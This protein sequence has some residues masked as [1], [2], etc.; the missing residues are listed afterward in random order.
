MSFA[1]DIKAFALKCG[2]NADFVVRSVVLDIGKSL[3]MKTPV[4]NPDLWQNPEKKPKG[5]AG[6]HAR[7][8]WQHSVN[9]RV[10]EDIDC[11]DKS[12]RA[13]IDRIQS[14][15]PEKAAGQ[16]HYVQN[17]VPYIEAL[18]DGHSRQAPNGMVALTAVEFQDYVAAALAGLK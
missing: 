4:G 12:G 1:D 13:S 10:I 16:V 5:Y 11:V 2:A 14:T 18:E 3:V 6:G 7:G 15:I 8:N 9:E 17:S